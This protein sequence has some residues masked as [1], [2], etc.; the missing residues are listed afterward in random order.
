MKAGKDNNGVMRMRKGVRIGALLAA[1]M[2][3]CSCTLPWQSNEPQ[4][5]VTVSEAQIGADLYTY[6]LSQILHDPKAY[7]L[8]DPERSEAE[9]KAVELCTQGVAVNTLFA[10]Q[11]LRLTPEY[12]TRIAENVSVKWS[13]YQNYYEE[14][15]V[16]KQ[17]LTA[18]ETTAAKRELLIANKYGK[19]GS[20]E[21]SQIELDANYAVN[22]VTFQSINGY[23]T[24]TGADGQ[25]ERLPQNEITAIENRFKQM[26]DDIRT[27]TSIETVSKENESAA[28]ILSGEA[29][30]VTINRTTSNY[31]PEFF[32]R[33]QQMEIGAPRVIETEDYIFLV[34]K[35]A[36]KSDEN[37]EAHRFACLLDMCAEPFGKELAARIAG[38]K[39]Q[40][41][42]AALGEIY[43]QV[44]K[45]F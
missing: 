1:L 39:V 19:G 30:T 22:Y 3:L 31:P 41:N 33:V 43:T 2:M 27:G 29:Q 44:S 37:L 36:P 8:T 45:R 5:V 24:R 21:V 38:Y 35:L 25:S 34:V 7:G 13:L 16:R 11:G 4:T 14:V 28:G 20:A 42:T 12:K 15:G 17:T 40:K 9:Q 18:Y 23:L 6:Y 26:C 32:T 10:E